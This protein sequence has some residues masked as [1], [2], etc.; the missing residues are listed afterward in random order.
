MAAELDD[1][2]WFFQ[3]VEG[4]QCICWKGEPQNSKEKTKR[5]KLKDTLDK[6]HRETL[7]LNT[8][9]GLERREICNIIFTTDDIDKW[10]ILFSELYE[11]R[12]FTQMSDYLPGGY[13]HAWKE[14]GR[15]VVTMNFYATTSKIMVQPGQQDEKQLFSWIRDFKEIKS[16]PPQTTSQKHKKQITKLRSKSQAKP[17]MNSDIDEEAG[18]DGLVSDCTSMR[19]GDED[20]HNSRVTANLTED[21][22]EALVGCEGGQEDILLRA[23][24]DSHHVSPIDVKSKLQDDEDETELKC[25]GKKST[26]ETQDDEDETEVKYGE[27]RN[28]HDPQDDGGI[29]KNQDDGGIKKNLQV[30]NHGSL[31]PKRDTH[32]QL[33]EIPVE[34]IQSKIQAL[35]DTL[36]TTINEYRNDFLNAKIETLSTQVK[37]HQAE[38]NRWRKEYESLKKTHQESKQAVP[39]SDHCGNCEK[40][41]PQVE[42]ALVQNEQLEIKIKT[43]EQERNICHKRISELEK[44]LQQ[45]KMR[46][47]TVAMDLETTTT[48]MGLLQQE[49]CKERE[50]HADWCL[51]IE[52][53]LESRL[54]SSLNGQEPV[55][56]GETKAHYSAVLI[57]PPPLRDH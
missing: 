3:E 34:L 30:E 43:V 45:I 4:V 27:K 53:L 29:K 47:E 26:C 57:N 15:T 37:M 56:N 38:A 35:E 28:A 11:S 31:A 18:V 44:E 10:E 52:K 14:E 39:A 50:N 19:S 21:D 40:I 32:K 22:E 51:N 6:T 23:S 42:S 8:I 7:M 36:V 48:K 24:L 12:K 16:N 46:N 13:Q 1:K 5:R 49:L 17:K 54:E 9:Q 55:K 33:N 20:E 41:K 25:V 2:L